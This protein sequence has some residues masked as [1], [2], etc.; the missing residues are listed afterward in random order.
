[1]N[2][3]GLDGRVA[4]VIGGASGVGRGVVLGLSAVGMRVV[5]ADIDL[6]GGG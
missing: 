2:A 3:S 5:V 4:V 1:M 6:D